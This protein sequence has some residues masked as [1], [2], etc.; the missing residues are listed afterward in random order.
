ME[1]QITYEI[2]N[3]KIRN[4]LDSAGRGAYYWARNNLRYSSGVEEVMTGKGTQII[5]YEQDPTQS[6]TLTKERVIQ[7]LALMARK[8]PQDFA[9]ILTD[10]YDNNTGDAFLQFCIFGELIYS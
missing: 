7:G 5:D 10:D 2:D 6:Y 3:E 1:I 8:S 4:L 9:D